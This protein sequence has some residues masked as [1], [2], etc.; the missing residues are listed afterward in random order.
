V[1]AT[2]LDDGR[3]S[4]VGY[5]LVWQDVT[6]AIRRE[7]RLAVLNRVLRH[8]LRNDLNVVRGYAEAAADTIHDESVVA[9]LDSVVG[10]ADD[11]AAL[12]ATAR[13]VETL[14]A[15]DPRPEPVALDALLSAVVADARD[16][17]PAATVALE[18]PAVTV[19]ADRKTLR[20][21]CAELVD[22][23]VAHAGPEPS[24][25]VSVTTGPEGVA[26]SVADD[27]PGLPKNELAVVE[28][29]EE[30]PLEHGSGLGLWLVRWGSR[31]LG[32]ELSFDVSGDG[33]TATLTLPAA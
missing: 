25:A 27:G 13:D 28:S 15:G 23:A 20:T 14:L 30:T 5:T 18:C 26:V 6:A 1:T 7:Q 21:V 11:L 8:N 24:V 19:N 22:N 16:A 17:T 12:G 10:K 32:A 29:G 3:G 4:L 31:R 33:T 9:M 2:P